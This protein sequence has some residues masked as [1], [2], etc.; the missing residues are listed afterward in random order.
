MKNL[1]IAILIASLAIMVPVSP[2]QAEMVT[3]DEALT[4]ANNW[5]TLIIHNEGDWGGS[6]SAEVE[7]IEEFKRGERVIGYFCHVKP[8]GFIVVSLR[9]ELAPVK[10]YSAVSD[11]DPESDEGMADVIKM[12]MDGILNAIEQQIGPVQ[13]ARTE[14]V[15]N[16][17]E[18]NHR[19]TWD[20]LGGN[21]ETFKAGLESGVIEM[22]YE[23]GEW[24]LS[25]DWHQ[26][27]PYNDQCPDKGCTWYPC[28]SNENA[29]VGCVATAGAQIMRYW[30]WPPYRYYAWAP[31]DWRNMPDNFTGCSWSQVQV[32]AVARLC[33]EV[34][35]AAGMDYGCGESTAYVGHWAGR[36][37]TEAYIEHFGYN[38]KTNFEQRWHYS[39][40][41]WF[42]IIKTNI[43]KNRPVQYAILDVSLG[44]PPVGLAAHSMVCDGWKVEGSTRMCHMNYGWPGNSSDI[45]YNIDN[46]PDSDAEGMIR[47]IKPAPSLGS[48]LKSDTYEKEKFPYRYFDQDATGHDATFE[49]GQNLQFLPGITVKCTG[50]KIQFIGWSNDNTRLF[51][52][53]DMSKGIRIHSGKINLYKEGS[54]KFQ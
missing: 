20:E 52:R 2:V 24:L 46:L 34:G 11:L 44:W 28:Y 33:H 51:T 27:P 45:W 36:T 30:S 17:L 41:A 9:K 23:K 50:K 3:V 48:W 18:T 26:G 53:G 38:E 29:C 42:N 13:S 1:I 15:K 22:N 12:R 16:I 14:D 4:V 5:I 32:N 47:R 21:V 49:A 40:E 31:Y 35:L 6:E 8:K 19:P 10:A 25:S 54:I 39:D 43:N 7:E 37:M